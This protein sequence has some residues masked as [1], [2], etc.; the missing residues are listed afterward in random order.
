MIISA[1][2]PGPSPLRTSRRRTSAHGRSGKRGDLHRHDAATSGRQ[3]DDRLEGAHAIRILD[4]GSD[5]DVTVTDESQVRWFSAGR[6]GTLGPLVRRLVHATKIST[7]AAGD[8][9]RLDHGTLVAGR[10]T[11]DRVPEPS[12]DGTPLLDAAPPGVSHRLFP[13]SA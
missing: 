13:R 12:E 1:A 5:G 3:H 4:G 7:A 2:T 11:A 6:A 9:E 8:V 10:G